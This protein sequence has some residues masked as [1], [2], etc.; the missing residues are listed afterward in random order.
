[1]NIYEELASGIIDDVSEIIENNYPEI[2]PKHITDDKSIESPALINGT[3]YYDLE[4]EIA[5]K[6]K[7]KFEKLMRLF[8]ADL[9]DVCEDNQVMKDEIKTYFKQKCKEFEL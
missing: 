7:S 8:E 9:I 3:I 4:D 6:I 2:K 1:M 5:G